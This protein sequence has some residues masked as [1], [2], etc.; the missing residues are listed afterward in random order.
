MSQILYYTDDGECMKM[1]D[2]KVK[3]EMNTTND[4]NK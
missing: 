1:M 4:K 2:I 3:G